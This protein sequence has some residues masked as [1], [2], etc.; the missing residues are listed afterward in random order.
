MCLT[1]WISVPKQKCPNLATKYVVGTQKIAKI[2]WLLWEVSICGISV[3]K[4]FA[5]PVVGKTD[6]VVDT[7]VTTLIVSVVRRSP[8][9][10]QQG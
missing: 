7:S 1:L 8:G 9:K 10:E 3:M 5:L 2:A 6:C 4:N